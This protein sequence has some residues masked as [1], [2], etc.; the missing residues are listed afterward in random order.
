MRSGPARQQPSARSVAIV[1]RRGVDRGDRIFT[2]RDG[3]ISSVV[4]QKFAR[5]LLRV[6]KANF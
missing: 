5:F 6:R 1:E 4:V 3:L 2:D